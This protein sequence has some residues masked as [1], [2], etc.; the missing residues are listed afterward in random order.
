MCS[1]VVGTFS[2]L[3]IIDIEIALEVSTGE[4]SLS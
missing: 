3:E 2:S 4:M 1:D